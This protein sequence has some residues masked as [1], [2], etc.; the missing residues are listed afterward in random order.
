MHQV[1]NMGHRL[2]VFCLPEVA[3]KVIELSQEFD[4]DARSLEEPKRLKGRWGQP[5]SI[6]R[7]GL[8]LRYG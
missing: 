2:E 3:S 5:S 7:D 1:Y 4:V 8:T 6:L